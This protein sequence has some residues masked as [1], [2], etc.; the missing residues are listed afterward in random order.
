MGKNNL[1]FTEARDS[2]WSGISW[3][4]CKSAP[5]SREITTPATHHSRVFYRPDA[6]P[7]AQSSGGVLVWLSLWSEV[8]TCIRP[9]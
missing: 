8:Q 1:D 4:I 2:E 3:A 5:R 6:L 9:S 7:A